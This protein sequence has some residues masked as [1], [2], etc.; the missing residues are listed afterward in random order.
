MRFLY[1][2]L[3]Y[4]YTLLCSFFGCN[5]VG[6][7][8]T[9]ATLIIGLSK[10]Y[11]WSNLVL[12]IKQSALETGYWESNFM[13]NFNNPFGMHFPTIRPTTA[14]GSVSGDGGQVS[15]YDNIYDGVLDRFMWDDYNNIQG[16]SQTYLSDIQDYGYNPSADYPNLVNGI[17]QSSYLTLSILVIIIVIAF[18]YLIFKTIKTL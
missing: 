11:S 17:P 6:A 16:D 8:V 9:L 5:K 7:K 12:L 4:P 1:N 13:V 2:L 3:L 15:T 18:T 10:G 14:T